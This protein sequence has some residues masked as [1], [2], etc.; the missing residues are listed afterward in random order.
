MKYTETMTKA[1]QN[2]KGFTLIELLI[3]VAIIGILAAVGMPMYQG[4]IADSKISASKE[5]HKRASDFISATLTKCAAG[6]SSVKLKNSA[7]TTADRSCGDSVSAFSGYFITHFQSD[8]W[9]NSY[10]SSEDAIISTTANVG[11]TQLTDDGT[12]T[13]TLLTRINSTVTDNMQSSMIKE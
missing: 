10:N 7:T 6:A 2:K 12:D 13:I 11:Q 1:R 5:T 8:G 3:V 4:F 9:K